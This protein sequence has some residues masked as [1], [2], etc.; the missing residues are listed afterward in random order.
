M[1]TRPTYLKVG[2]EINNYWISIENEKRRKKRQNVIP[3]V[4]WL[5]KED[6]IIYKKDF[7][8]GDDT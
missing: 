5:N 3:Y 4:T 2:A 1:D 6:I 8:L 7:Q